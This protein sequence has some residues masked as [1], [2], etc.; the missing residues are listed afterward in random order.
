LEDAV[1]AT[2]RKAGADHD[3][4]TFEVKRNELRRL[5]ESLRP[6]QVAEASTRLAREVSMEAVDTAGGPV[7]VT[8]TGERFAQ[9]GPVLDGAAPVADSLAEL[10][11]VSEEAA[12]K[13]KRMEELYARLPESP[14]RPAVAA[15]LADLGTEPEDA[16]QRYNVVLAALREGSTTL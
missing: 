12:A 1:Q 3:P 14:S 5:I 2:A 6:Y 13:T 15:A 11:S 8:D 9:A 4:D 16:A 7:I 10:A